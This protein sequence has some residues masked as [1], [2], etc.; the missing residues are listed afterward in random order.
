MIGA[1]LVYKALFSKL[2]Q[3][4]GAVLL[5][6]ALAGG[7]YRYGHHRGRVDEQAAF[8]AKIN[9]ENEEAGNAAEDWR[10]RYRRCAERGRMFDF[11]T[12]TCEP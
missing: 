4:L 10:V 3:A 1:S 5:V 6:L 9:Q 2:G 11:A 12:G 7:I 8:A